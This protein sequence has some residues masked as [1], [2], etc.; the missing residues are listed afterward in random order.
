MVGGFV[1]NRIKQ[2]VEGSHPN[3]TGVVIQTCELDKGETWVYHYHRMSTKV[4]L[5]DH[6]DNCV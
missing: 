5:F 2:I 6:V 1:S 3:Y 4:T